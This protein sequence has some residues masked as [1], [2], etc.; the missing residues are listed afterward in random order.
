MPTVLE[1]S[2]QPPP[3]PSQ[4]KCLEAAGSELLLEAEQNGTITLLLEVVIY[5]SNQPFQA[6]GGNVLACAVLTPGDVGASCWL[7]VLAAQI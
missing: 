7:S 5:K 1:A 2:C 3:G 4:Q 6:G